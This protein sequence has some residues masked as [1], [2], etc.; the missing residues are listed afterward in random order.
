[1]RRI[2]IISLLLLASCALSHAAQPFIRYGVEWGS[3]GTLFTAKHQNYTV[4][5]GYRVDENHAGWT[6]I[7]NAQILADLGVNITPHIAVAAYTGMAGIAEG[8]RVIPLTMRGTYYFKEMD[9]DGMLCYFDGGVG[10]KEIRNPSKICTLLSAGTGYHVALSRSV[11]LDF[12]FSARAS[13][14]RPDIV[15]PDSGRKI[16]E[17]S[18]RLDQA[19]Y[20]S[21]NISI[22]LN[23]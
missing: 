20:Y 19:S 6:F 9:C 8:F 23:F 15:D 18:I 1:M 10:F 21:L 5:E 7:G 14:D 11:S 4:G 13:L 17:S 16:P 3:S 12:L 22:A 2:I